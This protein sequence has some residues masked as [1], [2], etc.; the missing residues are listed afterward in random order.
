MG[1]YLLRGTWWIYSQGREQ[2][3]GAPQDARGDI[4]PSAADLFQC[5]C[6]LGRVLAIYYAFPNEN[7]FR[8]LPL[9]RRD[10]LE[11]S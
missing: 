6:L 10:Y 8:L 4:G 11:A 9:G 7:P 2:A 1:T 5:P 3:Q